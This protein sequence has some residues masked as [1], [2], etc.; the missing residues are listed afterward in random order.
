MIQITA[1]AKTIKPQTICLTN[2]VDSAVNA[3]KDLAERWTASKK[4]RTA[5][6]DGLFAM[7]RYSDGKL[8]QLISI[9]PCPIPAGDEPGQPKRKAKA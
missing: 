5:E 8:A 2:T 4:G 6:I 1:E 3:M 9:D 7:M